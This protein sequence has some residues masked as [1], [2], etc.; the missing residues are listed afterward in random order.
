MLPEPEAAVL[1]GKYGI[2]YPAHD[3]VQSAA[4]AVKA[5]ERLGFPV[6]LKVVSPDATHKSD[7]GGV[8]VSIQGADSVE[9]AF[10]AIVQSV[11]SHVPD[12]RIPGM[13]VCQQAP[14]GLEVI[15]GGLQDAMFG[16]ALMFGLGGIF[17]EVLEDVT[18]RIVPVER[19]DAQ[20]MIREIR[21]Y[22]LL[23]GTRGHGG[24]DVEALVDL[25]LAVS[26]MMAEHSEIQELDLNP[27]RVYEKGVLALDARLLLAGRE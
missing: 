9:P 3:Y 17:A 26:R 8:A 16:P 19:P 11:R 21:G 22:R 4:G 14:P 18:F 13:L 24:Y 1:L 6:V 10:E 5:A 2:A 20:E 27:V 15:V 12:A 25:L 7:V 23:A